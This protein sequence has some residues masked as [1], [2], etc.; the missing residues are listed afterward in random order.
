[1]P[2]A[3]AKK[4]NGSVLPKNQLLAYEAQL[5]ALIHAGRAEEAVDWYTHHPNMAFPRAFNQFA[6]GVDAQ[7]I[8]RMYPNAVRILARL[9]ADGEVGDG[10]HLHKLGVGV[11]KCLGRHHRCLAWHR[12][13]P[14]LP[15]TPADAADDEACRVPLFVTGVD[16][17]GFAAATPEPDANS[18][19]NEF[20]AAVR[21]VA[22]RVGRPYLRAF[23]I[24][25]RYEYE[26]DTTWGAYIHLARLA[27]LDERG[28]V[29]KFRSWRT[30]PDSSAPLN[31][32]VIRQVRRI[33][34]RAIERIRDVAR[35][36]GYDLPPG[37]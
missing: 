26:F 12:H 15:V 3:L 27:V 22:R 17:A 4:P 18:H 19:R 2:K 10:K 8:D 28:R 33:H 16:T 23:H 21:R 5:D 6:K 36:L 13:H 9:I 1:M 31:P 24:Y 11:L 32:R 34:L 35:Q 14:F 30:P 7:G 29:A 25:R 37:V 20:L